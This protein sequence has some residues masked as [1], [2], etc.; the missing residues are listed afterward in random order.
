MPIKMKV[1]LVKLRGKDKEIFILNYEDDD[2]IIAYRK[3]TTGPFYRGRVQL[4]KIA[5]EVRKKV[6]DFELYQKVIKAKEPKN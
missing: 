5:V 4:D 2:A 3:S 1:G 6:V